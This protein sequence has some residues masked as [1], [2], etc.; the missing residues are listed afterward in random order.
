MTINVKFTFSVGDTTRDNLQ[1]VLS[2]P[3]KIW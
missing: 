1:L 2:K 3:N